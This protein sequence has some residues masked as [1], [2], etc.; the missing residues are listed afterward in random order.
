LSD[1]LSTS[2]GPAGSA[3]LIFSKHCG[4]VVTSDGSTLLKSLDVQQPAAR[5]LVELAGLQDMEVGDGTSSVVVLAAELVRKGMSLVRQKI[6][7][8]CV[9]AGFR[10]A[11]KA[12]INFISSRLAIPVAELGDECLVNCGRTSLFSKGLGLYLEFYS[13]MVVEAV[14]AVKKVNLDVGSFFYPVWN[15]NILKIQGECICGTRLLPGFAMCLSRIS[16][17][18][19]AVV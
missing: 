13:R 12:S 8:G 18:M 16:R 6:H 4:A 3:K 2:L 7:P 15:I 14:M 9:I 17:M 19:P 5:I 10:T 11:M 1:I